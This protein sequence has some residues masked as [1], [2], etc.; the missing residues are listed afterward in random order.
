M[1]ILGIETTC[2]ETSVS[3]VE[4]GTLVISNIVATSSDLHAKSG[5]IIP[6]QAARKQIEYI[7]PVLEKCLEET[8]KTL[9]LK[10]NQ[11]KKRQISEILNSTID[12][13]A[14][15]VGPGLI[16]SLLVGVETAKTIAFVTGK[17]I[18]PINHLVAH[19]YA[20]WITES[21]TSPYKTTNSHIHK[22]KGH[23]VPELP[24]IALVVSG[25]HTDLVYM[26]NHGKIEW[27]G[28][29]KDDAAG[30]AFDKTARLLGLPYPGGVYLS[31]LADEYLSIPQNKHNKL[32]LF[33]RPMIESKNFDFSFSGL[34]TAVLRKIQDKDNKM[35]KSELAAQI[36]EA[37]VES[38][39]YKTLKTIE[40]YKPKSLIIGGGV[41]ANK[42][43]REMFVNQIST[44]YPHVKFFAPI[45]KYSTD[46]AAPIA[47]CAY[48]NYKPTQWKLIN[49]NSS[50]TIAGEK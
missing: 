38:L 48:F 26:K 35:T 16:G 1:R 4:N 20:N 23:S 2:D 43:L 21:A 32:N 9:K 6:E 12:A 29:T 25:G 31:K 24:A 14:V 15:A 22:P 30:E 47:A 5:G 36:Q 3:V 28:G 45:P 10:F 8:S 7:I 50:L 33:P 17:P 44:S 46:N 42:R 27:I 41:S 18:I 40:K 49:A 39:V 19:I 11:T 34:K 13:I 37:I